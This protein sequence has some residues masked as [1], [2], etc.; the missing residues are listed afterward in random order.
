MSR[1]IDERVVEMRFDNAQFEA[2]TKKTLGTL[3][4][5]KLALK[6]TNS[7]KEIDKIGKSFQDIRL[8]GIAS[9]VEMLTKRFSTFGIVGMQ[10]IQNI[11]NALSTKLVGAMKKAE[12]AIVSGGIRRAMNI[13]NAHFQLQALLK[14]EEK[15]QAVMADAMESVDGT[16]YAYDEAAKAAAM[17]SASGIKAGDDMLGAL[18][19]ITG[20]AAMTNSEFEAISMIFTTVAG[21][22]RLMGDQ[23]LQLSSRGLNAASTLA[24]YM[25][26]VQKQSDIT[27]ADI[28][29]MVSDGEISFKLFADAMNWAFGDSAKRANE[30]FTGAMSNMKSALARIGAGFISPLIEQNGVLVD[31]FNTTRLKI[32]DVKKELV[33]DEATSAVSGLAKSLGMTSEAAQS[34]YDKVKDSGKVTVDAITNIK[35][36][37]QN[38][39]KELKRYFNG[40]TDGSIRASYAITSTVDTLTKGNEITKKDIRKWVKSGEIDFATWSAAVENAF[41]TEHQKLSKQFTDSVIKVVDQ[42]RTELENFDV[43][44]ITKTAYKGFNSLKNVLYGL[45]T[46]IKPIGKAFSN[47]FLGFDYNDISHLATE[48]ENLTK[49]F[50]LSDESAEKLERTFTG[51]FD[52]IGLFGD[53]VLALIQAFLPFGNT[54]SEGSGSLL[55][56]S[57]NLGDALSKFSK[58][59]RTS[60]KVEKGFQIFSKGVSTTAKAISVAGHGIA[61][62]ISMIWKLDATQK[63]ISKTGKA[64]SNF[65]DLV[66]VIAEGAV[67]GVSEFIELL[68]KMNVKNPKEA[69]DA[70]SKTFTDFDSSLMKN[71][72]IRTFVENFNKFLKEMD[73]AFSGDTI[74]KKVNGLKK[75]FSSLMGTL[76]GFGKFIQTYIFPLFDEISLGGVASAGLGVGI[77]ASIYKLSK[78]LENVAKTVKSVPDFLNPIKDTLNA[79]QKDLNASSI[80]KIAGAIAILAGALVL[81]SFTDATGLA[82]ATAALAAVSGGLIG[83]FTAFS[84][85]VEKFKSTPSAVERL[86]DGLSKS[87]NNLANAVKWKAIGGAMKAFGI[88]IGLIV[89]SIAAIAYMWN[90][91]PGALN[92][93][94]DLVV[95][96]G[97]GIAAMVA[98]MA[99]VSTLLGKGT[100]NFKSAATGVLMLSASLLVIVTAV[101]KLMDISIPRDF[102]T[103]MEI[104]KD[105]FSGLGILTIVVAAASAISGGKKLASAPILALAAFLMVSVE[106][107][108]KVFEMDLPSDYEE[109]LDIFKKLFVELGAL[110]LVIGAASRIS[111]GGKLAFAPIIALGGFL[112]LAVNSLKKLMSIDMPSDWGK[113][114]AALEGMF[115][116]LGAVMVAVSAA[117]RLSGGALKATGT[118]LAMSVFLGTVTASLTVLS[119]VDGAKLLKGAVALGSVLVALGTALSGAGK[120]A[121]PNAYKSVLSMAVTVGAITAS[122]GVLSMISWADL[123]KSTLALGSILLALAADFTAIG[124]INNKSAYANVIAMVG[125][126]VTIVGSLMILAQFDWPGL[127]AAGAAMSSVLLAFSGAMYILSQSKGIN[128]KQMISFLEASLIMAPIAAALFALAGRPWEGLLAAGVAMSGVILAFA[129]AMTMISSRTGIKPDKIQNFLLASLVMVPIAASLFML[130]E[131]PWEGLLAAS[132]AMSLTLISY[133][134]SMRILSSTRGIDTKKIGM[135]V[136]AT[137]AMLPLAA[138]IGQLA[139]YPWEGLLAAGTAMSEVI[140]SISA[141]LVLVSIAGQN[142]AAAQKGLVLLGEAIAGV[143]V[144]VAAAGALNEIPGVQEFVSGG[145]DLL[146]KIGEAFGKLIAGIGVGVA[147]GLPQIGAYLSGF[148]LNL[149][150]FLSVMRTVDDSVTSGVLSIA[151]MILALTATAVINGVMSFLGGG[152]D[153]VSVGEELEK[154]GPHIANFA[155]SVKNIDP[156]AVAAAASAGMMIAKLYSALPRE[157]GWI[158]KIIGEKNSLSDFANELVAFGPAIA[159]FAEIVKDVKPEAVQGAASAANIMAELYNKLPDSGGLKQKIFG[160]G[161]TLTEF[162]TELVTFGPSIAL[163]A[164]IVKD[165]KPAA[166]RGA[167]AAAG[168]MASLYEKLPNTGG[169]KEKIFGGGMSL[170]QFGAELVSFGP[171]IARF[172]N[173][174]KDIKSTAA[175]GAAVIGLVMSNLANNLPSTKT[176]AE[177][178][179]GGGKTTLNEFGKQIV[180][181]APN[182]VNFAETVKDIQPGS[183]RGAMEACTLI[184][185]TTASITSQESSK[186]GLRS[187]GL[188]LEQFGKSLKKFYDNMAST[189]FSNIT[190]ITMNIKKLVSVAK[191]AGKQGADAFVNSFNSKNGNVVKAVNNLINKAITTLNG[192]RSRFSSSGKAAGKQYISGI[193][194]AIGT[195]TPALKRSAQNL[196]KYYTQG[197][198]KGMRDNIDIVARAAKAM[199][200]K[201]DDEV[202]KT[203]DEHSPSK[204]AEQR[205]KWYDQGLANGLTKNMNLPIAA[206]ALVAKQTNLQFERNLTIQHHT[207]REIDGVISEMKRLSFAVKYISK[208]MEFVSALIQSRILL[209]QSAIAKGYSDISKMIQKYES[210]QKKME[211]AQQEADEKQQKYEEEVQKQQ[212][213]LK[214]SAKERAEKAK[215]DAKEAKILA[216]AQEIAYKKIYG[217]QKSAMKDMLDTTSSYYKNL[218]AVK[219]AGNN[220]ILY[221][222]KTFTEFEIDIL[223]RITDTLQKYNEKFEE[224]RQSIMDQMNFFDEVERKEVKT[225]EQLIQNAK[226]QLDIYQEWI[227]TQQMLKVKIGDTALG[228]YLATLGVESVD[229]LKVI[230][231]MTDAELTE[232]VSLYD[233]KFELSTIAAKNQLSKFQKEVEDELMDILGGFIDTINLFDFAAAMNGGLEE[234][235]GPKQSKKTAKALSENITKVFKK[236]GPD[237]SKS[238]GIPMGSLIGAGVGSGE[239]A[240]ILKQQP[241][242]SK[243][244]WKAIDKTGKENN[245]KAKKAGQETANYGIK[246]LEDLVGGAFGVGQ[247]AGDQLAQGL[248]STF[249]V[250][251]NAARQLASV[252]GGLGAMAIGGFSG[253]ISAGITH[254]GGGGRDLGNAFVGGL[255]SSLK[256]HSPSRVTWKLAEYT[257]EGFLGKIIASGLKVF[258]EAEKMGEMAAL[259]LEEGTEVVTSIFDDLLIDPVI[260]PILDTSGIEKSVDEMTKLFNDSVRIVAE[261]VSVTA[262]VA[263]KTISKKNGHEELERPKGTTNTSYT[264]NQYNSS[265]KALSAI[266]IYRNTRNQFSQ[267]REAVSR[268]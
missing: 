177:K 91:D 49:N 252:L 204:V 127:L 186:S 25:R 169:L 233:Q 223:Q 178:F 164:E 23:L 120:I 76:K 227:K 73:Q 198:S 205:G 14:D 243:E 132:A 119:L 195:L 122:L 149:N 210:Q 42:V 57:A 197:F 36:H 229:Q 200:K 10:I 251:E 28:R 203:L 46:V 196:G 146:A 59:V 72:G 116:T 259:G 29:D 117:G 247:S 207:K 179:F 5:L 34:F 219:Q 44:K 37:G 239:I 104:L 166:V 115:I 9:G 69:L 40:V 16:A 22:G 124:K 256:I 112:Y 84:K 97:L 98:A 137:V 2:E 32:N 70:L 145:G 240:E 134:E 20:V 254:V 128:A 93:A 125:A 157:G 209:M 78:S 250:V 27:E 35:S 220:K 19:G 268:T 79:Y 131:K 86:A 211:K 61:E 7:G 150:P 202:A 30:T 82:R 212:E 170:S 206:A 43:T 222:D 172:A 199:A 190:S 52:I 75:A 80:I 264:F 167:S 221:E 225:K 111:G 45:W 56:L 261:D 95:E 144:V 133:A 1:S 224:T 114:F 265:P 136:L 60:P 74:E 188:E 143:A 113:R 184:V 92:K 11:T 163:F 12:D 142:A 230:N 100:R 105:L 267:F 245:P 58:W 108:R 18:K 185:N 4:R 39:Y 110:T 17:F 235:F 138:S 175:N 83:V 226:D 141:A 156:A 242:I 109:K 154:F 231:E 101:E 31:L 153:F 165:V 234:I 51:V 50:R 88:T 218:M 152:V 260:T 201:A 171:S 213:Y 102:E 148:A 87:M 24:D 140:L 121:D 3:E 33:F 155:N 180:A 89:A 90:K 228:E 129:E 85:I 161:K 123:L 216:K 194:S 103:R 13:E 181:F 183:V 208:P 6:F 71:E 189:D 77:V 253:G 160:E 215:E 81:L 55:D 238:A 118:I 66:S 168:I 232:Y 258:Q 246:G 96:L 151:K 107:L 147:S 21:N 68:D 8:D 135:F 47:V 257:V 193:T 162:A 263:S 106:A 38:G 94:I 244:Y 41:G 248:L 15:V 176:L 53:G 214:M 192:A 130:A 187:F 99:L 173:I 26:E 48:I 262:S 139:N 249:G 64:F 266:D 54:I 237:L 65:G 217:D 159:K 62:F 255:A 174:V 182:I 63:V 241:G 191:D 236:L 126:L 67:D 158:Q